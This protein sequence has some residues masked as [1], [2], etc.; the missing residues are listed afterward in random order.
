MPMNKGDWGSLKEILIHVMG[1]LFG[2]SITFVV[3]WVL[4]LAETS[5]GYLYCIGV[6]GILGP[7]FIIE[8]KRKNINYK[9]EKEE[10]KKWEDFAKMKRPGWP[11]NKNDPLTPEEIEQ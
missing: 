1:L 7:F 9:K 5:K 2:S 4:I 8:Q 3:L 10:K 6:I 11:W